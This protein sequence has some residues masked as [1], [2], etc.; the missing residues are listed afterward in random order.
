MALFPQK[1]S[2]AAILA[3]LSSLLDSMTW[4]DNEQE[5]GTER[6]RRESDIKGFSVGPCPAVCRRFLTIAWSWRSAFQLEEN[7]NGFFLST[8]GALCMVP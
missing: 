7:V 6:A 1:S 8:D 3:F 5:V 2:F 4:V